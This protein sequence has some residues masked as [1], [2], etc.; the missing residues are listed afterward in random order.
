MNRESRAKGDELCRRS[1][2]HLGG[3]HDSE[4][5][6]DF[7]GQF[8]TSLSQAAVEAVVFEVLPTPLEEVEGG[9][10][11]RQELHFD[12]M[13]MS[14]FGLYQLALSRSSLAI[15]PSVGTS[16]VLAS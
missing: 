1:G 14:D 2:R 8:I 7:V 15:P 3:D 9:T 16:L 11:G 13:S 5:F 10:V 4:K 12:A 6:E